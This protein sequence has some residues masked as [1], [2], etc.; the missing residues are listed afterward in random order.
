MSIAAVDRNRTRARTQKL[1]VN[2]LPMLLE[3]GLHR[4]RNR[5]MTW[6]RSS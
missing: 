1:S 6:Q 2:L 3:Y 5:G 4:R